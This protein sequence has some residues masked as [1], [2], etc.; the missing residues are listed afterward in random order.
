MIMFFFFF[1]ELKKCGIRALTIQYFIITYEVLCYLVYISPNPTL[2]G[3]EPSDFH[4]FAQY[5]LQGPFPPPPPPRFHTNSWRVVVSALFS[6]CKEER[7]K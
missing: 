2:F 6:I 7:N 4:L 3:H 1:L 5:I